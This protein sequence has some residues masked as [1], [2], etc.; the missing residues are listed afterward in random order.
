M[1]RCMESCVLDLPIPLTFGT[2]RSVARHII[3]NT[4]CPD[5]PLSESQWGEESAPDQ[6]FI[7]CH[8]AHFISVA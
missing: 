8:I 2:S 5:F 1:I 4:L 3:G 6:D 7:E